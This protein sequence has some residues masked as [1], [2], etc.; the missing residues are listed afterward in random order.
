MATSSSTALYV[1]TSPR[2]ATR[3]HQ[4]LFSGT[5]VYCGKPYDELR[6]H[7]ESRLELC[8]R[9]VSKAVDARPLTGRDTSS[10]EFRVRQYGQFA[11]PVVT[12]KPRNSYRLKT[13]LDMAGHV[14]DD[15]LKKRFHSCVHTRA[16]YPSGI[17]PL[18]L[19]EIVHKIRPGYGE[20]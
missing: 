1:C 15:E 11:V 5:E 12:V 19:D 4:T 18:A 8:E 20:I 13:C 7:N 2:R 9:V 6:D 16:W 10:I 17:P 3:R 14:S